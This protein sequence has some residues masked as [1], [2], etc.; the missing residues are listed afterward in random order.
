LERSRSLAFTALDAGLTPDFLLSLE[1]GEAVP[2]WEDI[3]NLAETL[4]VPVWKFYFDD[5][6]QVVTPRLRPRLAL[7]ELERC[8]VTKRAR[9][10]F[11]IIL[12]LRHRR[13]G[14][15]H[16]LGSDLS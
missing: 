8:G 5:P 1:K 4:D 14:R 6:R 16:G 11:M 13:R 10:R 15:R 9:K 12:R 3:E 2:T 7:E